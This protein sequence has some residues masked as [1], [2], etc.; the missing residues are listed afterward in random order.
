MDLYGL[1]NETAHY[2][3]NRVVVNVQE[4]N[5]GLIES[6]RAEWKLAYLGGYLEEDPSSIPDTVFLTQSS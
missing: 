2:L 6:I 3:Y 4:L 1:Q 5:S